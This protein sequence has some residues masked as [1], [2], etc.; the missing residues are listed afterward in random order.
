MNHQ[1][2]PAQQL[3]QQA[4]QPVEPTEQ[5]KKWHAKN[6]W[7][8]NAD[9]EEHTQATQFAYFTHFNLINEGF[10]IHIVGDKL[11][12]PKVSN[13]GYVKNKELDKLQ[14]KSR[15]TI[16]SEENIYSIFTLECIA[17]NVLILINKTNQFKLTF[18]KKRFIR[19]NFNNL[20]ELRKLNKLYKKKP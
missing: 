15:F 8:G 7:Y 6:S 17:N 18:F 4:Q 16:C 13:H 11:N 20:N 12:V 3:Q 19:I 1:E 9:D 5:A 2:Q 14:F 10:N